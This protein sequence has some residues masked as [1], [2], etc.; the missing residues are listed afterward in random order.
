MLNYAASP[1]DIRFIPLY[2]HGD[3]NRLNEFSARFQLAVG[4]SAG[5]TIPYIFRFQSIEGESV[6]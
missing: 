4:A 2:A 1:K 6:V 3:H 5:L